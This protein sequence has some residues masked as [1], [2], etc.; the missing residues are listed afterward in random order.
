MKTRHLIILSVTCLLV[1]QAGLAQTTGTI[2]INGTDPEAFSI[3]NT[4]N[5][6]L[7]ATVVLGVLTPATGGTLTSGSTQ[8]R[9]R[10]NKAYQLTAQATALNFVGPG[11]ADGGNS[12]ALG[13]FG[14]GISSINTAGA[15]VANA[16]GHTAVALF[17]YDPSATAV[18]NGLTPYVP[19][20]HG[21]LNDITA[22]TQILSGPRISV[23]GNI[24][25]D[26]NFITPTLVVATLPQY[27]TPNTSFS[28]TITLT[29]ASQ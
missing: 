15:N 1:S 19:G 18:V 8:I 26:N 25:T 9:L 13:D 11:A 16:A 10:S 21:T 6:V 12:I 7:S 23:Q 29:I 20:T 28:T 17:N 3:T 4:S 22:S 2:T 24:S 27:F 5:A 14:F